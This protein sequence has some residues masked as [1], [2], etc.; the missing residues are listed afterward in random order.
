MKATVK[1]ILMLMMVVLMIAPVRAQVETGSISGT[2]RDTSGAAVAGAT[3]TAHNVATSAERSVTTG[4]NG[5]FNI[6]ALPPGIYELT[7]T[8]TGFAKFTSRVEVTVGSSVTVDPQLSVGNQTTTIEVVAAGG[9]EVNTQNQELS[10]VINT[11]Q[12]EQLPSLTRNPY[13]FVQL[14]GNVSSGDRTAAGGDQNQ[15]NR[16][17]GVN[18]NGQ[19]SSGTEVLL[20]GVE[21]VDIFTADVGEQVPLDS[22]QEFRVVTSDFDA[23]YGRA[24]G[25]VVNVTTKSGANSLHGGL[26]EFNRLSAYTANTFGNAVTGA[27]KGTYTRNQFGY[28]V[29]GPIIKDKLFFFQSTEWLRVRSN[30]VNQAFVPTPQ[31]IAASAPNIRSYFA[32]NGPQQFNFASTF[33]R[34][35]VESQVGTTGGPFDAIPASTPVL[36]L[37]DFRAPNDAGGGVPQNT[38]RIMGRADFN[39]N[40]STQMFFRYVLENIVDFNG[41]DYASVYPQYNVG[42]SSYNNSGMFSISHTF[43]PTLFS[44]SKISF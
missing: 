27:P 12:M 13:D 34:A 41:S 26:W 43:S 17:A 20:D 24:S 37:V 22:V 31:L 25:G 6:P 19:R 8:S 4:D 1:T 35:Q 21:N 14:A 5:Q 36:G 29:G 2:V 28:D 9:V 32:A 44:N 11:Q 3:V 39:L 16:G 7:V 42:D 33:T 38:Y 40:N 18:I 15:T 10:Q 30:G 23:Q